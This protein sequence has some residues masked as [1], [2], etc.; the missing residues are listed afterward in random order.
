MPYFCKFLKV[1]SILC[2]NLFLRFPSFDAVIKSNRMN[3]KNVNGKGNYLRLDDSQTG[4]T[5]MNIDEIMF[6][7]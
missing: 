6:K 4:K 2:E 3:K 1:P 7:D 5:L